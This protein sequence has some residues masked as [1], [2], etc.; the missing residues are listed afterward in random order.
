MILRVLDAA[1]RWRRVK[2]QVRVAHHR[3]LVR[4]LRADRFLVRAGMR[5]VRNAHRMV[6]DRARADALARR[7][8]AVAV[9]DDLVAVHARV[10]IGAR[11]RGGAEAD[12]PRH[13]A[14]H[15]RTARRERPVPGRRQV[16]ARHPRLE[17]ED[18]ERPRIHAAVPA[19]DVE[20]R[21]LDREAVPAAFATHDQLADAFVVRRAQLRALEVAL[22]VRRIHA[23]LADLVAPL[24]QNV[25]AAVQR[26]PEPVLV[27]AGNEA[28]QHTARH[29]DV[30][31]LRELHVTDER[32]QRAAAL[33]DVDELVG[34]AGGDV[35]RIL[36]GRKRDA[37]DQIRVVDERRA[38]SD[39]RTAARR[40]LAGDVVPLRERALGG[41]RR[42]GPAVLRVRDALQVRTALVI[43][44]RVRAVEAVARE[45]LL[46]SQL[47]AFAAQL[48]MVLLRDVADLHAIEHLEQPSL[49]LIALDALEQRAKIARA[50]AAVA[51]ALDDLVE[52]RAGVRVAVESRRRLEEDLQHVRVVGCA[53]DQHRELAQR[54]DVLVDL[55]DAALLDA[56][57]EHVVVGARRR[58]ERHAVRA[59]L[60]HRREDV[61]DRQR[62]V[63]HA[64]AAQLFIEDV[65]LR[66]IEERPRRL[67]VSE[68]RVRLGVTHHDRL[69]ARAR[70]APRLAVTGVERDLPHL[71]EAHHVLE[72]QQH[73]L[74]RLEVRCDVIDLLEAEL[75]VAAAGV[76]N[77]ARP[78][79]RE[80]IALAEPERRVAE[81]RGDREL[82]QH[83]ATLTDR[84][85]VGDRRA[86][87]LLEQAERLLDVLDLEAQRAD[88]VGV[89][90]EEAGGAATFADRLAAHDLDVAR[91]E[92]RRLLAALL[93]ELRRA[94]PGLREVELVDVELPRPLEVVHVVVDAFEPLDTEGFELGHGYFTASGCWSG[95]AFLKPGSARQF[96]SIRRRRSWRATSAPSRRAAASC[97]TRKQSAS[98]TSSPTQNLPAVSAAAVAT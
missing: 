83:A 49:P 1:R 65:D 91:L 39:L 89:I 84:L 56:L 40:Q 35:D 62:D 92:R 77:R 18:R 69:E 37:G 8:V 68:L 72:P 28:V 81:R 85:D 78:Q 38:R 12:E 47:T 95:A 86:A 88:A 52:E 50:E 22:A 4:A 3:H 25:E 42:C 98:A 19:D 51:L 6:R 80:R 64:I 27:T 46:V 16:H 43:E 57:G 9:E 54:L 75:V 79:R 7:E 96:S 23:E 70:L 63:L 2:R 14:A 24:L 11:D 13:E 73:R 94:A 41:L 93:L 90:R 45:A 15:E 48:H 29:E 82:A 5:A 87:A 58:H 71:L 20:R 30:I 60:A 67:V 34:G 17:R 33:V 55:L 36:G 66:A 31:A 74:H 44:D 26:H 76:W 10:R 32:A 53:V 59:Q 21:V 61:L 97:G